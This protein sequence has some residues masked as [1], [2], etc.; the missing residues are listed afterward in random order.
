MLKLIASD[1]DG[2]LLQNGVRTLSDTVI[3]QIKQLKEMGILFVAASGRQYTNLQ[4]LFAPV[5]EDIA[6][7]CENGA[8]VVYKGKIL[9][10][11]VFERELAE[12]MLHSILK[13]DRAELVVSGERTVY[14]QPKTEAFREYMINFVKN[15]TTVLPDIFQV[16]EE[17]IKISVYEENGAEAIAPYWK[18]AFGSR[19][20]VVTSGISWLDMMPLSADKGNGL[21]VLKK[22]LLLSDENCA[23]FGDNFNDL[24]MLQEVTYGFAVGEARKEVRETAG[25]VTDRVETVLEK[26]IKQG[27]NW[28]E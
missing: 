17:I 19:A 5:C 7:V 23:A 2:T 21:R 26:V 27:G 25:R 16:P 11:N 15:D 12:E 8:L 3:E 6:Y 18:K 28:Y 4:R 9:H 10:K 20:T 1:L 13:R 14:L 22:H 24:E